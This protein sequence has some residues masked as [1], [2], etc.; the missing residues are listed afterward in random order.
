MNR[1]EVLKLFESKASALDKAHT[2]SQDTVL[3]LADVITHCSS[4]LAKEDIDSLVHIGGTLVKQND[5][6][7]RAR[8]EVTATMQD[9][10]DAASRSQS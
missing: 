10:H 8:S 1:D 3:L 6:Q 2:R 7:T 9:S 4:H 5:A